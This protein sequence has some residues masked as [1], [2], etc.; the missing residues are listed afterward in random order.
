MLSKIKNLLKLLPQFYKFYLQR[1]PADGPIVAKSGPTGRFGMSLD[2]YYSKIKKLA[3]D[4]FDV[5]TIGEDIYKDR[6][7]PIYKIIKRPAQQAINQRKVLIFAAVHGNEFASALAAY[8]LILDMKKNA[9]LMK[10]EI[11]VVTPVNPVGLENNSRYDSNGCD[12]NRDFKRFHTVGARV[13]R[14]VIADFQPDIIISFHEGMQKDFFFIT[15]KSVSQDLIE[16][17]KTE[18]ERNKIKLLSDVS[19]VD[20]GHLKERRLIRGIKKVLGVH[21]LGSYA[22][23]LG[24]P[25]ITTESP[26]GEKNVRKRVSP[27]IIVVKRVC[28]L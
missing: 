16:S 13:Q 7:Y 8:E 26:W 11:C 17:I 27:H 3:K 28:K 23:S 9:N 6:K 12:I 2:E 20:N 22:E 19:F 4:G 1:C 15:T 24:I 10:C 14:D 21:T 25:V 18:L 5:E